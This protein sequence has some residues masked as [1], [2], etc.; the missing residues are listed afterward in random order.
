MVY[1][2]I[3]DVATQVSMVYMVYFKSS[4]QRLNHEDRKTD[5]FFK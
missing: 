1:T 4:I 5:H 3:D 2:S